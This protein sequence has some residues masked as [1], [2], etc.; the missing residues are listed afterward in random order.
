MK[1][2]GNW[3]KCVRSSGKYFE[4]ASGQLLAGVLILWCSSCGWVELKKC[5]QGDSYYSVGG[6]TTFISF[7]RVARLLSLQIRLLQIIADCSR[8]LSLSWREWDMMQR[9]FFFAVVKKVSATASRKLL[10]C[11]GFFCL[12]QV[13]FFTWRNWELACSC[14]LA[15]C[16]VFGSYHSH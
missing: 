4:S 10:F 8:R 5:F 7:V 3:T 11:R 6:G 2:N 12:Q 1:L 9:P 13:L 15:L 16:G 14:M